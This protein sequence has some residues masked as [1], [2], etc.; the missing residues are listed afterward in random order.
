MS[1]TKKDSELMKRLVREGKQ[2]SKI[3]SENFPELTYWDVYVEV[4]GAGNRSAQGIKRMITTR[5]TKLESANKKERGELIEEINILVLDLYN[6][7]RYN[8][9]KMD[10]IRKALNE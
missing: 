6:N 10:K 4:Y 3:V 5:L 1:I 9:K 2:I 8:Q 7:Y